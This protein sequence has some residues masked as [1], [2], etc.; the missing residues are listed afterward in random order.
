MKAFVTGA[1][2]FIGSHVVETMLER[3]WDVLALVRYNSSGGR[4]SLGAGIKNAADERYKVEGQE[5]RS[6]GNIQTAYY[7]NP[8]TWNVMFEMNF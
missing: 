4:W 7:G 5:F 1:G 6:V 2:G 3:G 8:R